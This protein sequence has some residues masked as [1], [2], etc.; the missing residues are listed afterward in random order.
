MHLVLLSFRKFVFFFILEPFSCTTLQCEFPRVCNLL[1]RG[2]VCIEGR[3][4]EEDGVCIDVD[5]CEENNGECSHLCVN[6]N[7]GYKCECPEYLDLDKEDEK[8]CR[9]KETFLA[10]E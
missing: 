10:N 5:E 9:G 3:F 1:S 6:T 8:T 2:C 4:T 7:G